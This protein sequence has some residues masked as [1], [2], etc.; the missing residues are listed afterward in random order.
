MFEAVGFADHEGSGLL[1]ACP[2]KYSPATRSH[3]DLISVKLKIDRAN[4][5]RLRARKRQQAHRAFAKQPHTD[6]GRNIIKAV[7]YD[8]GR[9]PR[10][11][12]LFFHN[13]LPNLFGLVD[14]HV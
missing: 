6:V 10:N 8:C 13:P 9:V 11:V 1:S 3:H 2:F 4:I 12:R 5:G 14:R 7:F